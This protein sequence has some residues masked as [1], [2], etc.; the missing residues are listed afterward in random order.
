MLDATLDIGKSGTGE[1]TVKGATT[2]TATLDYKVVRQVI[3]V[4]LKCDCRKKTTASAYVR[5]YQQHGQE[6]ARGLHGAIKSQMA[7]TKVATM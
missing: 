7:S 5:E 1:S 3:E 4:S 6:Y 2:M